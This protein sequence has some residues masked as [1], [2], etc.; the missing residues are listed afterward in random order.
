MHGANSSIDRAGFMT[1]LLHAAHASVLR[2]RT[3][4]GFPVGDRAPA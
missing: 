4:L 2:K 3:Q 1:G